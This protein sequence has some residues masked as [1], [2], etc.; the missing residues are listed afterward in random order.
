[1]CACKNY[2]P[3]PF[4]TETPQ[5]KDSYPIYR[6]RDNGQTVQ[7]RGK[8]LDN[9]WVVPYNPYLLRRYNCHIN[10]EVCSSIKAVRY[11]F[12]Y[13]YKGHDRASIV[14]DEVANNG[15]IDEIK[16]YRDSRWVT[17]P[18]AL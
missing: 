1:M 3:C 16:Q 8:T 13:I 2:Y 11:L 6:R 12:K 7:V 17:P 15:N 9:G 10:V 5:G 14:V 18:E 4:N